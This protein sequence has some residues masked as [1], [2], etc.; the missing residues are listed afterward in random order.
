MA[1]KG[2]SN[3]TNNQVDFICKKL[4]ARA[5]DQYASTQE[6]YEEKLKAEVLKFDRT[7]ATNLIFA[8][9]YSLKSLWVNWELQRILGL[10][11]KVRLRIRT[12]TKQAT[13][14]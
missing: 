6:D 5:R 13:M 2:D 7:R 11:S 9:K 12:I 4:K 14:A 3:I 1:R 8:I 10:G